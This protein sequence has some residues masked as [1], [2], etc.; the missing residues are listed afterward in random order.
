[1]AAAHGDFEL[2]AFLPLIA[3]CLIESLSLMEKG[4]MIFREKCI[5]LIVPDEERCK[6]LLSRSCAFATSYTPLLGYKTVSNIL[7]SCA[8]DPKRTKAALEKAI[9]EKKSEK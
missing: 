9:D 5:D 6:E 3:E 7:K 2:N 1:M 8:G 4:V